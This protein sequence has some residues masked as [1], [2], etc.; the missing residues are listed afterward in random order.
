M[1]CGLEMGK[2]PGE[3]KGRDV[4]H[5]WH[6]VADDRFTNVQAGQGLVAGG[7][8][9]REREGAPLCGAAAM[10]ELHIMHFCV[11]GAFI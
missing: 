1:R 8:G 7:G 3:E 9:G 10:A 11:L 6:L 5:T 4:S 2:C